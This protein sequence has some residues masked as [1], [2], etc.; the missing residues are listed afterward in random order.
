VKKKQKSVI[1]INRKMPLRALSLHEEQ[2]NRPSPK[3]R[4]MIKLGT[5]CAE[6]Q[7]QSPLIQ[8]ETAKLTETL[9]KKEQR[10]RRVRPKSS[11]LLSK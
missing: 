6:S 5:V 11:I 3:K 1:K 10:K 9:E 8:I 2:S 7:D 4:V